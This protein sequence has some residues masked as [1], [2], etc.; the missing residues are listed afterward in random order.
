MLPTSRPSYGPSMMPS[1]SPSGMPSARPSAVPSDSTAPSVLP[2]AFP[3]RSQSPSLKPSSAPSISPVPSFA[4]TNVCNNVTIDFDTYPDGTPTLNGEY[5]STEWFDSYGVI[6][7][8]SGGYL[9]IP[10]LLNTSD[11]SVEN[12]LGSPN[13]KCTPPGPGSGEGGEPGMPG[14]NCVP[15]GNVLIIQESNSEIPDDNRDGGNITF[16]F[17]PN[18]DIVYSI[19]LMDI[20]GTNTAIKVVHE[21]RF[22]TQNETTIIVIGLGN[23]A[24]QTVPIN[25]ENVSELTVNLAGSGAV[26]FISYCFIAGGGSRPPTLLTPMPNPPSPSPTTSPTGAQQGKVVGV[27]FEDTNGNGIQDVGEPGIPYVDVVITDSSGA[28]QT[29]TT[30]MNG[31]YTVVVPTGPTVTD[32]DDTTLPLGAEQ[33]AGTDPTTLVVV[34]GGTVTDSDGFQLVGRVEGVVFEDVNGNGVQDPS[35]PGIVDVNVIVTDS[36]GV[37]QTLTTDENGRYRVIVSAGLAVTD[38]DES[39]LP[40]GAKQ[41]SGSDPTTLEVPTGG[42]VSDL[43]GFLFVGRID[44]LVFEDVNGNGMQDPGESGIPNVDVVITDSLGVSQ[45]VTTDTNGKYSVVV[46]TGPTVINIDESTLPQGALQTAGDDPSTLDV[47]VGV[48]A[49]ESDGFLIPSE[50][51]STDPT[52]ASLVP[53]FAPTTLCSNV[54]I[55][56]D[57]FPGNT[58]TIGGAYVSNEWFDAYGLILSADGGYLNIPRLLNTSEPGTD[59]DLGSPNKECT[60]PGPGSGE[61][62]VPGMPGENC[63]PQGNV[64]IIQESNSEMPDDNRG[65][66]VISFD[67]SPNA[68]S[69]YLIGLMDIGGN[70]TTIT[71]VYEDVV[72]GIPTETTIIVIGLGDNAVQAV[73]INITNVSQLRVNLGGSGAV[74]FISYCFSDDGGSRPPTLTTQFPSQTPSPSPAPSQLLSTSPS[75]MPSSGLPSPPLHIDGYLIV[76]IIFSV[77]P[78]GSASTSGAYVSI[79]WL[80]LGLTLS[81]S[82][83]S[84]FPRLLNTSNMS[85]VLGSPNEKCTPSGPGLGEGGEPGMPGEN[86]DSLDNVLIVQQS[87]SELPAASNIGGVIECTFSSKVLVVYSV[88]LFGIEGGGTT[89]TVFHA[90]GS[91]TTTI[92][93]IGLGQNSVQTVSIGIEGVARLLVNLSGS[94]AVVNIGI[95]T[96]AGEDSPQ[97][98]EPTPT[99]VVSSGGS[100]DLHAG[101]SYVTVDFNTMTDGTP[102]ESGSYVSNVWLDEIGFSLSASGGIS[103]SPRLLDTSIAGSILAKEK[104]IRSNGEFTGAN[105]EPIGN[106]LIVQSNS[107]TDENV[108]EPNSEGGII[109]FLFSPAISLVY[110]VGVISANHSSITVVHK[111][112]TQTTKLSVTPLGLDHVQSVAIDLTQVSQIDVH[113]SGI[114]AVTDIAMGKDPNLVIRQ[115]DETPMPSQFVS[116]AVPATPAVKESLTSL[117]PSQAPSLVLP[118]GDVDSNYQDVAN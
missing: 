111:D 55:D 116:Y 85:G 15:Q 26:T 69:V 117:F 21:D 33:T 6:L 36:S 71:V 104:C 11:S 29:V 68:E 64:L 23:N 113:L 58:P 98:L 88:R 42:T 118:K 61:D 102:T 31:K 79:E 101:L 28:S 115:D 60:P 92:S 13:K 89:I 63:I 100:D 24:V 72:S 105:C 78:S 75:F 57:T 27:V 77:F 41:T 25:I 20:G 94:G 35:E 48:T 80:E 95:G 65:G 10:R 107:E 9:D 97:S 93:V 7:S 83:D 112:E 17:S 109:S 59:R 73:P 66:G 70:T 53:S 3:S 86:C 46:P 45:T 52:S 106:V 50:S 96:D 91:R 47:S 22:G 81:A 51:P 14:E 8:A 39:S 49:T 40:Y 12:D 5:V 76:F 54:T 74:T 16:D 114:G 99:P 37:S 38:I 1:T 43:D 110:S 82:G 4:P 87:N 18:A 19:G 34:A 2:S 84:G 103:T 44:G 108:P 67:F 56:F 90:D 32:I 30:D 62:G